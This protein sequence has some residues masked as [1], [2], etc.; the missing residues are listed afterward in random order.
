MNVQSFL[1]KADEMNVNRLAA[2]RMKV[3]YLLSC[4]EAYLEDGGDLALHW[5]D[6][7]LKVLI[8]QR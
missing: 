8:N 5:A 6:E 4:I 7:D 2:A 3:R 1:F